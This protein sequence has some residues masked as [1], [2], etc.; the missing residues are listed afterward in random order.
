MKLRK[1]TIPEMNQNALQ[2]Y[3]LL[4]FYTD[5]VLRV[6]VDEAGMSGNDFWAFGNGN[7]NYKY[8]SQHSGPEW[9][10]A[11]QCELGK[12]GFKS[13]GKKSGSGI[14]AHGCN[15]CDRELHCSYFSDT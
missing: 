1:I 12:K 8:C 4:Y 3:Y 14:P 6:N 11:S 10:I 13:A 9:K 2:T 7:G 5:L 15:R